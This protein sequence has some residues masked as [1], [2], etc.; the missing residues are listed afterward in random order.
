MNHIRDCL[1][2]LKKKLSKKIQETSAELS[3]YG[4]PMY[5]SP[6]SKVLLS[7]FIVLHLPLIDINQKQGRT[8]TLHYH[9]VLDR[10]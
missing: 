3:S 9:E 4:D 7:F 8:A 6:N 5:D 1:P 10:L 2:E